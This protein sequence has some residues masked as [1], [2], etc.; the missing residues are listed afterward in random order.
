MGVEILS[1]G[2]KF[3]RQYY[4]GNDFT[5]NPSE[6]GFNLTGSVMER[7]KIIQ[8]IDIS[9]FAKAS[10][11]NIFN[12]TSN[13][14]TRQLGTWEDDGIG[15]G[16][17]IEVNS[18]DYIVTSVSDTILITNISI[19]GTVGDRNNV[20][21]YG[22][23]ALTALIYKYN[24]VENQE[25]V[26][27]TS[28][29]SGE[30]LAF[31]TSGINTVAKDLE[32]LGKFN[33]VKTGLATVK[34]VTNANPYVQ[35]FE[36]THD[37]VVNPYYIDGQLNNLLEKK[38]PQLFDGLNSIKYI[39]EFEFRRDLSDPSAA[40]I[41]NI[42]NILGS[43]GW[44]DENF[45]G[46]DSNYTL[47][48]ITYQD[49]A[50]SQTVDG[51]QINGK[52]NV[53]VVVDKITGNFASGNKAGVYFSY[54]PPVE[55]Y[56]ETLTTFQDNF[57]YDNQFHTEG[58][59]ATAGTD[60]ITNVDSSISGNQLT[61]TY[62]VEFDS[63]RITR[64]ADANEPYFLFGIQVGDINIPYGDSDNVMLSVVG[65][66]ETT[67]DIPDLVNTEQIR[68]YRHDM[69]EDN[70][71]TQY[72]QLGLWVEDGILC[73]YNF[74]IDLSKSAF[75]NNI[76]H[77]L[78]A[79][80][81]VTGE[82]FELDSYNINTSD[83]TRVSGV[84]QLELSTTRGY[85]LADS[86]QFN[87]VLLSTGNLNGDLQSYELQIGQKISYQDWEE[88]KDAD[89]IF[90]D[91]T[92]PFNNLNKKAS[93]YSDANNYTIRCALLMSVSGVSINNIEGVT[94]YLVSSPECK[95]DDYDTPTDIIAT[96]K[97]FDPVTN[98]D[99][100]GQIYSDKETLFKTTWSGYDVTGGVED[101]WAIHRIQI[102]NQDPIY[103]LSSINDSINNNPLIP[104]IGE[105]LLKVEA[106]GSEVVTS[107]LINPSSLPTSSNYKLSARIDNGSPPL[108]TKTTEFGTMKTTENNEP[109]TLE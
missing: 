89:P 88:L 11:S 52:T 29:V 91:K 27:F 58:T 100:E 87:R 47:N 71:D 3:L 41:A 25:Q 5:S 4:N 57:M 38:P 68:L 12:I 78:I 94:D 15:V 51:V 2:T 30:D 69:Q 50:T 54:L 82:Y 76:K 64:L 61:I 86:S 85:K 22:K 7:T 79:Y 26:N 39:G 77:V 70:V 35:S 37:L 1:T 53:T 90:Y 105:T 46:F 80:N 20:V 43:V 92:K 21:V 10:E 72:S 103:K 60:I 83:Y 24:L 106:V 6:Y 65:E 45:N 19:T 8:S 96:I 84:Q 74:N 107:C 95:I 36:I 93:N 32:V 55:D 13:R 16:D 59:S 23:S 104:I 62:S 81:N 67:I 56:T 18:N 109:K 28:K 99:L 31:Y 17:T 34:S 44:F 101:F 75:L 102:E 33:S 97:T 40:K 98:V 49:D 66:F 73:K 42:N 9:Y 108:A 48:S 63:S 14:I